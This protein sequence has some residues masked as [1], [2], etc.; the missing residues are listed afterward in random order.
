MC[1]PVFCRKKVIDGVTEK[2]VFLVARVMIFDA[3]G[4]NGFVVLV[5]MV[6]DGAPNALDANQ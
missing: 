3:V 1:V 2:N 4:M 5:L 6:S